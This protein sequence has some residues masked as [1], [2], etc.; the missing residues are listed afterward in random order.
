MAS[1]RKP[2]NP[3]TEMLHDGI[4]RV[5]AGVETSV[6]QQLKA[7]E[8]GVKLLAAEN[9]IKDDDDEGMFSQR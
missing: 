3:F 4:K 6:E 8:I 7:I 1:P 2:K 9:K 5:L